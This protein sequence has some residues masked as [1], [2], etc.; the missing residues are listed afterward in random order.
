MK[1]Q[2]MK[3]YQNM[4][5]YVEG[6]LGLTLLTML[7]GCSVCSLYKEGQ[8]L[9]PRNCHVDRNILTQIG[10]DKVQK[11]YRV[12]IT[13]NVFFGTRARF[14]GDHNKF[15]PK[16]EYEWPMVCEIMAVCIWTHK[17]FGTF[18]YSQCDDFE[19]AATYGLTPMVVNMG[20][21]TYSVLVGHSLE[22]DQFTFD[23]LLQP[24]NHLNRLV[25]EGGKVNL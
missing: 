5:R 16:E 3:C 19:I 2:V 9:M 4:A 11:T 10:D 12:L 7:K 18:P 1:Y 17:V 6:D 20:G 22:E 23:C 14:V 13:N 21:S 8:A 15:M 25:G 24:R